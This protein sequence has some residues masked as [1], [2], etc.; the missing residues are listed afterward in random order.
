[1]VIFGFH[2]AQLSVICLVWCFFYVSKYILYNSY[3]AIPVS[4]E[5]KTDIIIRQTF[6]MEKHS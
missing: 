5:L 3:K 4:L 6:K 2:E 1:M